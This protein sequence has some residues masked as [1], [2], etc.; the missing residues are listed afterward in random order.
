MNSFTINVK[1]ISSIYV[2]RDGMEICADMTS[3]Q[4]DDVL[5]EMLG[6]MTEQHVVAFLVGEYPDLIQEREE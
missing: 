2:R 3:P 1:S 5:R 4:R 6:S